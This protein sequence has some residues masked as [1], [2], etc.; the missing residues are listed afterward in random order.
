MKT[1]YSFR[2][3]ILVMAVLVMSQG[4]VLA[5]DAP[6]APASPLAVIDLSRVIDASAVG[7]DLQAKFKA[8]KDSLQ[9]EASGYEKDLQTKEQTL[10]ADRKSLDDKA[11]AEKKKSFE[12]DLKKKREVILQ[13]N[14]DLEKAKNIALKNIQDNVARICAKLAEEKKIQAVL[15]RTAV[16]IAQESLDITG[17]VIKKLDETMKTVDLK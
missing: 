10:L 12:M 16:V 7:K 11:F 5:A 8:K 15:D 14:M 1:I 13:K 2:S 3:F 4:A 6:A 17:D 9:K